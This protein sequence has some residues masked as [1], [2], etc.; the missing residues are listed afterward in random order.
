[1][2]ILSPGQASQP[3]GPA[4]EE[5]PENL[6]LKAKGVSSQ[7]FHRTE[8]NRNSTLEVYAQNLVCTR[9]KGRKSSDPIR[10]WVRST[11]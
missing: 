10:D 8:E 5:S 3:W 9:T 1:M 4:M 2:K 6:T 7:K 11:C